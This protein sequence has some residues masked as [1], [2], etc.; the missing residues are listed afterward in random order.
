MEDSF[1]SAAHW[2]FDEIHSSDSDDSEKQSTIDSD[3]ER[4]SRK[5]RRREEKLI[6]KASSKDHKRKD[7]KKKKE[8]RHKKHKKHRRETT[9]PNR[10]AADCAKS[11]DL[12]LRAGECPLAEL[13]KY[14][15][16]VTRAAA[17][18]EV[19]ND[20][21]R[22]A[23]DILGATFHFAACAGDLDGVQLLLQEGGV[24]VDWRSTT[25]D[26]GGLTALHTACLLCDGPLATLLVKHGAN[27]D[28]ETSSGESAKD[29][30]LD[31][32]LIDYANEVAAWEAK[33]RAEERERLEA[34]ELAR[35]VR[36][37]NGVGTVSDVY[38]CSPCINRQ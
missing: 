24:P 35:E 6:K 13:A 36:D 17:R 34:Q 21:A 14:L 33:K 26:S 31:D 20:D 29:M 8:K 38:L 12:L 19:A 16:R 4:D 10:S 1:Y 7:G 32:L 2:G 27:C 11:F 30:G 28:L 22:A 25:D 37:R 23:A 9:R 18:S 5:K 3:S 15:R